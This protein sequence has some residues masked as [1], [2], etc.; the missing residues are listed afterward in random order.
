MDVIFVAIFRST[1][2]LRL[3]S[4]LREI[5]FTYLIN[6]TSEYPLSGRLSGRATDARGF[7]G[8]WI[9]LPTGWWRFDAFLSEWSSES[10]H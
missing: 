10:D 8:F 3:H 9:T 7:A 5:V 1:E 6:R 2:N 4:G